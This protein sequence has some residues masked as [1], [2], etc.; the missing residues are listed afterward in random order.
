M[1]A[2][3]VSAQ[4]PVLS[5]NAVGYVK[6]QYSA[7]FA[8]GANPFE[9][10]GHPMT[11]PLVFANLPNLSRI[12]F[13]NGS[14]YQT[15]TKNFLGQWPAG[16]ADVELERGTAFWVQL[17]DATAGSVEVVYMGEVPSDEEFEINLAP[18]FNFVSFPYPATVE[19]KD[20]AL[21]QSIPNLS[22]VHF[23]VNGSYVTFTKNFLGNWPA[24]DIPVAP[25]QGF[26]VELPSTASSADVDLSKPYDWP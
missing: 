23:Y 18:G 2:G 22:R 16:A 19:W 14:S 4:E 7:G 3:L 21:A 20:T 25:G 11:I 8:V 1:T 5:R 24:G 17:P 15:F 6:Q 10:L 9:S 13:W 26:W 12:H